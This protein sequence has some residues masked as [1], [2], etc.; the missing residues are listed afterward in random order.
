MDTRKH[1]A[2]QRTRQL[3]NNKNDPTAVYLVVKQTK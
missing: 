3:E 1:N 2:E